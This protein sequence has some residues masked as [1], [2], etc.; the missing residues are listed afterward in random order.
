MMSWIYAGVASSLVIVSGLLHGMWTDRWARSDETVNA[1][2]ALANI[3][4][5]VGDWVGQEV[6]KPS[7]AA[8]GVT[9]SLQRTYTNKRT[10]V[11][12]SIAIVNGRPGPVGTHTPEVCYDSSGYMVGQKE[13]VAIDAGETPV[14]F[15][16]SEAVREKVTE[17][18]KLRLYWSWSVGTGWVASADARH[19]F[20]RYRHPILH[21]LY[22]VRDL[23]AQ[24][25]GS[26]KEEPCEAFLKQFVPALQASLF[27]G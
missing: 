11:S 14:Q 7:P 4:M 21:K 24:T 13:A 2:E 17:K 1:K 12:V 8:P 23:N 25:V 18:T 5:M 9:G 3:P 16:T 10:N 6:E 27:A 15:W 26:D 19:E 22:V 20:P